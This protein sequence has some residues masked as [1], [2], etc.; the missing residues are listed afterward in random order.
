MAV[1]YPAERIESIEGFGDLLLRAVRPDDRDA[2]GRFFGRLT[3]DDVRT[4]FFCGLRRL[5]QGHVDRLVTPDFEHEMALLAIESGGGE[6]L[7]VVRLAETDAG[8]EIAITVRSDLKHKGIG[9]RLLHRALD[10][11]R[12]HGTQDVYGDI[13]ADNRASIGLA[14]KF[15]F[16]VSRSPEAPHL[17]RARLRLGGT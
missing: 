5:S 6:I 15:G 11:A 1:R 10:Y 13:L 14:R 9:K 2:V 12:L 8:A 17:V 16:T 4:R 7:G 3:P